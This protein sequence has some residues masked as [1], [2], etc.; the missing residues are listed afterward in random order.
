M[1]RRK[2]PQDQTHSDVF[3]AIAHPVRRQILDRLRDGDESVNTLAEPFEMSRPAVSQ[4]LKILLDSGLV[5]KKRQGREQIYQLRAQKLQQIQS[6]LS[7]YDTFWEANL[8]SLEMFL[9]KED[10]D[11]AET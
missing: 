1:A 10:D 4:H 11:N 2:K 9:A 7:A 6:W 5:E 3:G 8:D